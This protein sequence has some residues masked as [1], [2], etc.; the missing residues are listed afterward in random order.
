MTEQE[1]LDLCAEAKKRTDAIKAL[2]SMATTGKALVK[3]TIGGPGHVSLVRITSCLGTLDVA[4]NMLVAATKHLATEP[5]VKNAD[6]NL[7]TEIFH[8]VNDLI[9][10]AKFNYA[11]F[12][13]LTEDPDRSTEELKDA[14]S[15]REIIL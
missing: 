4:S 15:K 9:E 8:A 2:L 10:V 5:T 1:K 14:A 3:M 12:Q 6:K 7:F 13:E 11:Y